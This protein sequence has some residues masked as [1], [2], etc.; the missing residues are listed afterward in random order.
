MEKAELV[1]IAVAEIEQPTFG[2][3]EQFLEVHQ[4]R[5]ENNI[6]VAAGII[7]SP[8]EQS[9]AV[10]FSVEGEKFYFVVYLSF[11]DKIEITGVDTE[12]Y[13]SVY[14]SATSETLS[15]AELA[16][17]TTLPF[18]TGWNKGDRRYP[19][20]P[21]RKFTRLIIEPTLAPDTFGSKL[22]KLLDVLEQDVAG[23]IKLVKQFDGYVQVAAVFHNSNTTLGGIHL[24]KAQVRRLAALNLEIDFDLYAEGNLFK[25]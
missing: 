5:R 3:T 19:N 18:P 6:P 25:S 12:D 16:I 22:D 11:T 10:Y 9:A 8:E 21:P 7:V 14:F 24:E 15:L 4:V 1:A 2:V 17:L 23:I 20:A 13:Y